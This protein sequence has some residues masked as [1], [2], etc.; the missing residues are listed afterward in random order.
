MSWVQK[1]REGSREMRRE[2]RGRQVGARCI[3]SSTVLYTV[4]W[5]VERDYITLSYLTLLVHDTP[6]TNRILT[7][8]SCWLI[9]IDD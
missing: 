9:I 8:M 3:A 4:A 2:A 7:E 5:K 6:A 1:G